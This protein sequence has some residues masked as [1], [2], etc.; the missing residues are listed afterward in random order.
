MM[1]LRSIETALILL[2]GGL[3]AAAENPTT[4]VEFHTLTQAGNQRRL[5]EPPN[6]PWMPRP[7]VAPAG[8]MPHCG[9]WER[10]GYKSMQVNVDARGC[11]IVGDAANE[12]SIAVD[13][14][15]PR[16]I[17]IGWRQFDSVLSDFRQAGWAYSHD[18]GHTWVFR[19][20]LDPGVF[21]SD[22]VLAAGPD[23]E[24]FYLSIGEVT[25]LFK[26]LDGGI[27]WDLRTQVV[28]YLYDKPWMTVDTTGGIGRGNIYI[29]RGGGRF[30]DPLT[31]GRL[32][33]SY[34]SLLCSET[35]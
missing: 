7:A 12:T 26:S 18:A 10:D 15:D 30:C 27:T 6:H 21:G 1:S 13:A 24:I 34:H 35:A 2:A 29:T 16:K 28:P 8:S 25:R 32:S 3:A 20:S 22:P 11:N 31:A 19:G 33:S 9:A 5:E 4:R 17:V 14:T 23:G